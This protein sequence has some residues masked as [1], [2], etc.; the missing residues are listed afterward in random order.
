MNSDLLTGWV[1]EW[2]IQSLLKTKK[3]MKN[4]TIINLILEVKF[5]VLGKIQVK[6]STAW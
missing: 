2:C 6:M 5:E 1:S 3:I 4:G